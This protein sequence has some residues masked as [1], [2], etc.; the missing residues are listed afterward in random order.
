MMAFMDRN[1]LTALLTALAVIPLYFKEP[2]QP[3]PER[4]QLVDS[5]LDRMNDGYM[6][7]ADS[8]HNG[9]RARKGPTG[10]WV[11][12]LNDE[13]LSRHDNENDA[14]FYLYN[15]LFEA[16]REILG[17]GFEPFHVDDRD[18]LGKRVYYRRRDQ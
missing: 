9:M 10:A 13:V 3:A 8:S 18:I 11:V 15:K 2:S 6:I 7:I 12:S 17:K 14:F 1:N 4:W 16:E 5:S